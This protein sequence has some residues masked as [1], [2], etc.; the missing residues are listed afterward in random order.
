MC[1]VK[2]EST[3][4][5]IEATE[6]TSK[7]FRKYLSNTNR[8]HE[9]KQLHKTAILGSARMRRKV[10]MQ[11]Y[12]SIMLRNGTTCCT[13]RDIRTAAILYNLETRFV[14]GI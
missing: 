11:Q 13:N 7:S 2:T 12:E 14:S 6:I 3:P 9:V 10:L 4:K 5:I 1:N 8:E